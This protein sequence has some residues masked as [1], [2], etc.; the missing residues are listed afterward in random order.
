MW[1]IPA[2]YEAAKTEFYLSEKSLLS[3]AAKQALSPPLPLT[4]YKN[5]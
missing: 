2:Y 3:I 1:S 4:Q 5:M